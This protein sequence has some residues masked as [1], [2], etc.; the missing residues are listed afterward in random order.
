MGQKI[1]KGVVFDIQR[2]SL[3]DGPGIRTTVFLKGCSLRCFWC[4]NPEGISSKPEIMFYPDKCVGCGACADGCPEG[5]HVFENDKHL[6]IRARCTACRKC[7]ETCYAG[8]LVVAGKMMSVEEVMDEV[9][10]DKTFYETSGGGVTLSG[11]DPLMQPQFSRAILERCKSEG[12]HTAIETAANCRWEDLIQM[13][14]VT[15]LVM[16]DIKHLNPDRHRE[17]TGVSNSL[18]LKNAER[19]AETDKPVIIRVPIIPGVNDNLEEISAIARFVQPFPNL[20]YLE[21]LPFHRL[22]QSKYR[23]LGLDYRAS[24][25]KTPS[26]EWMKKLASAARKPGVNVR[27]G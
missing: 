14:P 20:C 17:V 2:F 26:K 15:D 16:M 25:L 12:L 23:A 4:Q 24:G 5:A 11:G 10:R 13:L 27:I 18:I 6:F 21:L 7:V 19:L 22:G 3:H 1:V 8:A 9:L